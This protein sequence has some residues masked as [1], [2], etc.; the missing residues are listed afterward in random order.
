[1]A[2]E[3]HIHEYERPIPDIDFRFDDP[4]CHL[5]EGDPVLCHVL[6]AAWHG[7]G[8]QSVSVNLVPSHVRDLSLSLDGQEDHLQGE[9]DGPLNI[10]PFSL[11]VLSAPQRF[12]LL[13][14]ENLRS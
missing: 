5:E 3:I 7:G 14:C 1:M 9:F 11:H 2:Q 8:G 4:F 10:D 6:L 13:I 12:D